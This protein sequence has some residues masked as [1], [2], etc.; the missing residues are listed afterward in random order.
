MYLSVPNF[1]PAGLTLWYRGCYG[2]PRPVGWASGD[3]PTYPAVDVA[4]LTLVGPTVSHAAEVWG[5]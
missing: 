3:R 2:G 5:W 4:P 1:H